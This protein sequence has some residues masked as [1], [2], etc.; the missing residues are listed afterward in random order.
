MVI[1]LMLR[2][3][4]I[5]HLSLVLVLVLV[6]SVHRALVARSILRSSLRRILLSYIPIQSDTGDLFLLHTKEQ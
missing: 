6:R 2:A 4:S 1:I 5:S 3:C